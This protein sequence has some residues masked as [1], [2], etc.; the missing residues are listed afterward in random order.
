[1]VKDI[2]TS[3]QILMLKIGFRIKWMAEKIRKE[4]KVIKTCMWKKTKNKWKSFNFKIKIW[5]LITGCC[6]KNWATAVQE[7][8]DFLYFVFYQSIYTNINIQ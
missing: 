8:T 2:I 1:M 4:I 7:S 3:N 6:W 5:S